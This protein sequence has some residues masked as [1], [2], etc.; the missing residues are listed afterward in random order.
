MQTIGACSTGEKWQE[1]AYLALRVVTGL[2]FFIHGYMKVFT[3]GV[4]G[5]TGFFASVGIPFAGLMAL[6]VSYG[7]L[8]GGL[9][10]ILGLFTHWVAKLNVIIMIGAIY[11]V[12]L[13]NGYSA[14]NGG[15]EYA[16]LILVANVVINSFGAGKYSLDAKRLNQTTS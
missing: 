15:Y 9:A 12:H 11:F 10:L 6:L 13:A 8:L 14:G 2:V 7:E 4:D 5:V 3:M 16:L 1:E